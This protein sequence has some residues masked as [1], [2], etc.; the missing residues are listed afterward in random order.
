MVSEIACPALGRAG[1]AESR[2]AYS[3]GEIDCFYGPDNRRLSGC[4]L[5]DIKTLDSGKH[6]LNPHNETSRFP[7]PQAQSACAAKSIVL[8][9][10]GLRREPFMMAFSVR[11]QPSHISASRKNSGRSKC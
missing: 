4:K 8:M 10:L 7:Q 11:P 3:S 6:A 1:Q 9:F 2:T 5:S